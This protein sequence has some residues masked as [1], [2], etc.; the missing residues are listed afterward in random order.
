VA[1]IP[2]FAVDRTEV[3]L[4]H[5][6]RLME[7]GRIPRLPVYVDS[8]M[9]LAALSVYR[10]AIAQGDPELRPELRGAGDPFDP[11]DLREARDVASSK[12]IHREGGPA[13]IV[14]AS[15]MATGGR[16]LHHLV[17]RLPDPRNS[18]ILVGYQ[19]SET[20]GRLL[21]EGRPFV[22]MLGRYVPVRAEVVDASAFSVHA[23]QGEL[24]DWLA[25]ASAPPGMVFVVH[26]EP[27]PAQV[28]R[29][30]I[31]SRLGQG[32]VVARHG[33]RVCIEPSARPGA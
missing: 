5:L 29:E 7:E 22:K 33:E 6:R 32:A 3:V 28:L 11:G 17:A 25:S 4:F 19:A 2:A 20:R 26:A 14:S 13:I 9:A 15:G 27:G 31:G 8:P 24:V 1:V 21:L 12:A 18:V 10:E 16:V 30:A 23:D